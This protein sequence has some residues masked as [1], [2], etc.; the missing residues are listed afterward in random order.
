MP[1]IILR[2]HPNVLGP[3]FV[4]V[5]LKYML[6]LYNFLGLQNTVSEGMGTLKVLELH[7]LTLNGEWFPHKR[8]KVLANFIQNVRKRIWQLLVI[9]KW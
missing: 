9:W 4:C 1:A 3:H 8:Q 7:Q 5:H 6:D 2:W